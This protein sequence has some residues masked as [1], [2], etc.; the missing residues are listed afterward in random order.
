MKQMQ[1]F[2]EEI[3][4]KALPKHQPWDHEIKLKPGKEPIF[5][6]IYILLEK[7]LGILHEYIDENLKKGFI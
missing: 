1:L 3:T 7:E 4:A 5:R 6:P 2:V